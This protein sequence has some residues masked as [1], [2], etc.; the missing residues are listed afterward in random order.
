[1]TCTMEANVPSHPV[2]GWDTQPEDAGPGAVPF[3]YDHICR[4]LGLLEWGDHC[5]AE[6][7][8]LG[9][10][11]RPGARKFTV[12]G[13]F[14][15]WQLM[16]NAA[17]EWSGRAEGVY[18]TLNPVEPRTRFRA[19]NRMEEWPKHSTSDEE[20]LCYRWLLIDCDP[21]RL[22]GVSATEE[23][24]ALA[25]ERAMIVRNFLLT[26]RGV[27]ASDLVLADSGNGAHVLL[28]VDL[29][30]DEEHRAESQARLRRF[31]QELDEQFSDDRV[32]VDL[33]THN[34]A[35][36]SKVYGTLAA[37]GDPHPENPHRLARLLE[38]PD[39]AI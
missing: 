11:R 8:V 9:A 16:A 25:I 32:K 36:I 5:V 13:Y 12:S 6:L 37:K 3:D 34:P 17:A 14:T 20:I 26:D 19:L 10:R 15:D 33:T 39:A 4:S 28:H 2:L 31:L 27:P 18:F 35:R 30:C 38:V 24:H 1:M 22:A 29:P 21:V 23:E 7:R